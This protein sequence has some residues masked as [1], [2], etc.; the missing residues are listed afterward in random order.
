MLSLI[1]TEIKNMASALYIKVYDRQRGESGKIKKD[2]L[3]GAFRY[4]E[5][6]AICACNFEE[7][8]IK[9]RGAIVYHH[10]DDEGYSFDDIAN[11][12]YSNASYNAKKRQ[13]KYFKDVGIAGEHSC[14]TKRP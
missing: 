5:D 10:K 11:I 4:A 14:L 9:I 6:A 3:V 1:T 7:S 8:I 13:Q 12:V 2:L